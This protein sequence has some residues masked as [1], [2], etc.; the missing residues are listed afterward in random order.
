M[1]GHFLDALKVT[2]LYDG[3]GATAPP[4]P[5]AEHGRIMSVSYIQPP[6]PF[7]N[8]SQTENQVGNTEDTSK[9]GTGDPTDC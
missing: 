6:L 7:T 3:K 8:L 9:Q 5:I 2:G 1:W 4:S